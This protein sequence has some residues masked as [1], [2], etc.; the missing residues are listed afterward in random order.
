MGKDNLI[1]KQIT[2]EKVDKWTLRRIDGRNDSLW[3]HLGDMLWVFCL[4]WFAGGSQE[5]RLELLQMRGLIVVS[6]R[7]CY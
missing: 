6:E 4:F 1:E 7:L 5:G 3:Q 2:F